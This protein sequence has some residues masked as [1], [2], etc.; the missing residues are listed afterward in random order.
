MSDRSRRPAPSEHVVV[1]AALAFAD[2]R[3]LAKLTVRRLAAELGAAPM[4]LY[5]H[6][7]SKEHLHDLMFDRLVQRLFPRHGAA[8]WQVEF[9]TAARQARATLLAH[10]HWIPL[11]TRTAVPA[12]SLGFYD[13]LL[14]L[15]A[16]DGF[17][18]VAAM[19]ALSL[20]MSFALGLV[21]TERMMAPEPGVVIPL[22]RLALVAEA[23]PSL[24]EA[25]THTSPVQ[26]PP[27]HAGV[28]TRFS[29]LVSVL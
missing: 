10:P 3:G 8:T 16:D 5:T 7:R 9:E 26:A 25:A 19:H 15:M 14:R 28:S 12:S 1:D 27:L 18:P 24:P 2:Q 4:T 13:H 6:F 21:L 11:L 23:L 17:S 29:S 20:A 22:R